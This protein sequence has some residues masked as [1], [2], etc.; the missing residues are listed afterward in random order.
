MTL[1]S[2]KLCSKCTDNPES[3]LSFFSPPLV[4]AFAYDVF[5]LNFSLLFTTELRVPQ[6]QFEWA[7][8]PMRTE[9]NSEPAVGRAVPAAAFPAGVY[10]SLFSHASRRSG[11]LY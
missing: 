5:C 1:K 3:V 11:L 2:F 8:R 4:P 7:I 6:D 9:Q 10:M